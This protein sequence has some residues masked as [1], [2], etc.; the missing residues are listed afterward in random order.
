[1]MFEMLD[2]LD[3]PAAVADVTYDDDALADTTPKLCTYAFKTTIGHLPIKSCFVL[4]AM[5]DH[6][7][8]SEQDWCRINTTAS[9]T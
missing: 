6:K 5:I 2:A 3:N 8:G 1:M 7:M 9:I 4:D